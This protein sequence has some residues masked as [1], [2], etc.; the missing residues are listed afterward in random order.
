MYFGNISDEELVQYHQQIQNN[1]VISLEE[2]LTSDLFKIVPVIVNSIYKVYPLFY[3]SEIYSNN[4]EDKIIENKCIL[5]EKKNTTFFTFKSEI[6][7]N[8]TVQ[9]EWMYDWA[10]GFKIYVFDAFTNSPIENV[11]C[12]ILHNGISY[13]K[14]TNSNGIAWILYPI[15]SKPSKVTLTYGGETIT[16]IGE[17]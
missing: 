7:F 2:A 1:F 6:V 16:V 11:I 5:C 10:Y 14:S 9:I 4:P 3:C 13:T 15:M 8:E 12:N 17:D